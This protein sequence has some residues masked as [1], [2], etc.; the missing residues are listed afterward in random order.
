MKQL[1][2]EPLPF[3]D[4]VIIYFVDMFGVNWIDFYH[5]ILVIIVGIAIGGWVAASYM[6]TTCNRSIHEA[7]E[8]NN[9]RKRK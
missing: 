8:E 9:K 2:D 6:Y 3:S 1:F 5:V 7:V 4:Y